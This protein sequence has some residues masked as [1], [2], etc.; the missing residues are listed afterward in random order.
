[1]EMDKKKFKYNRL[2]SLMSGDG[3]LPGQEIVVDPRNTFLGDN[4]VNHINTEYKIT[5]WSVLDEIDEKRLQVIRLKQKI[6]KIRRRKVYATGVK[7]EL[8]HSPKLTA[9]C[10]KRIKNRWND[11][12][13]VAVRWGG[14]TTRTNLRTESRKANMLRDLIDRFMITFVNNNYKISMVDGIFVRP[15]IAPE[16]LDKDKGT[17]SFLVDGENRFIPLAG[18]TIATAESEDEFLIFNWVG[19][20]V[21]PLDIYIS[22]FETPIKKW[23]ILSETAAPMCSMSKL[24]GKEIS[25][26]LPK[27]AL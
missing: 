23:L 19:S 22:K 7:K 1:M 16:Y 11:G 15:Q 9:L 21:S 14:L 13:S 12:H 24:L 17:S 2:W 18:Y 27:N 5:E 8:Q 20:N 10:S 6:S 4:Y 26:V 25:E 3:S